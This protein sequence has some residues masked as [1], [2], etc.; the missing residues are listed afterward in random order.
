MTERAGVTRDKNSPEHVCSQ[1]MALQ[2]LLEDKTHRILLPAETLGILQD[3]MLQ[4]TFELVYMIH[5]V[6]YT[7]LEYF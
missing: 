1:N 4:Q 7:L 6:I 3:D 5:T 2:E